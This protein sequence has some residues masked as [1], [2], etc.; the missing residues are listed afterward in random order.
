MFLN[1]NYKALFDLIRDS[2]EASGGDGEGY[3]YFRTSSIKEIADKFDEYQ[4]NDPILSKIGCSYGRHE[5]SENQIG[6]YR[7]QEGFTFFQ[8]EITKDLISHP[9]KPEIVLQLW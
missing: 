5:R 7:G 6:Y 1:E 3:I 9:F 8:G 4:K 2:V